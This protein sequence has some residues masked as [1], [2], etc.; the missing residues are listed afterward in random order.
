MLN[1]NM[2]YVCPVACHRQIG[3]RLLLTDPDGA[4]FL[5]MGDIDT[6]AVI[7]VPPGLARWIADHPNMIRIDGSRMWFDVASLPVRPAIDVAPE[8]TEQTWV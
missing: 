6:P 7:D 8:R 3:E 2:V 1:A 5:W 4:W